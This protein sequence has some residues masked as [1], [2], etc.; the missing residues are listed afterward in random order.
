MDKLNKLISKCKCGVYVSVNEHRDCYQTVKQKLDD[1]DRQDY[2]VIP[3]NILDK[4][5]ETNI[6]IEIQYYPETPIGFF[7]IYH[8][9]LDK[10]L[11]K[12]LESLK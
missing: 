1:I 2:L 10:A 8:W 5:I 4:M 9:N 11:D 6:W 3:K 12:A 7:K